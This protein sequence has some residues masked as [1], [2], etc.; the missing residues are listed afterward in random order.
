MLAEARGPSP[1][2]FKP[3]EFPG[4]ELPRDVGFWAWLKMVSS[5]VVVLSFCTVAWRTWMLTPWGMAASA[6][7][8]GVLTYITQPSRG[9]DRLVESLAV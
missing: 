9:I 6:V 3:I 8:L 5:A 2:Y 1:D 4:E 7:M